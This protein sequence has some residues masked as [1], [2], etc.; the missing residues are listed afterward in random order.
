MPVDTS[1]NSQNAPR[2]ISRKVANE[3]ETELKRAR[4]EISC[5]ECRRLKLKCDKKVPCGSCVRRGCPTICPNGS[6][7]T[8]QG[9]RFVL[10][11]TEHLHRKIVEMGQRIRQLEDALSIFQGGVSDEVHPLLAEDLL[12]IKFGP[13]APKSSNDATNESSNVPINSFGTL[14]INDGGESNYFGLSAG[15]EAGAELD[16]TSSSQPDEVPSMSADVSRLESSLPFSLTGIPDYDQCQSI[17]GSLLSLLPSYPRASALC[18]TYMEHAAWIF[19]PIRRE[20]LIDDILSPVYAFAQKI[21]SNTSESKVECP[22]H[23]IAVL[24]MVFAQGALMDLTL[25]S[26]NQEAEDYFHLGRVALSLRSVFESPTIHT[27]QAL[28]VMGYCYSN[29]SKQYAVNSACKL[30]QSVYRDPSR[31]NMSPKVVQRRRALFWEIFS[32]DLF[33]SLALGHCEFP[34]DETTTMND[35]GE[36]EIGFWRWKHTFTR[37][38]FS[39]VTELTLSAELPSYD[40]ILELDRKVREQVLPPPLNLYR[41]SVQEDYTTPSAYIRGRILFQ[42]RTT[43]MLFIHRSFFAQ[44]LLDFPTNPLRSPYA[45][46]FLAAYRCASATIKTTVLN[47]QVFPDLFMR[48]WP[49]WSHLLSAAVIVGSIVTRAPSTTMAP[50]AWQELNLAV[51]MFSRGSETSSRARHGLA[52]LDKLKVKAYQALEKYRSG[53]TS[54][55]QGSLP[56]LLPEVGGDDELAMFGGQ[57]RVLVTKI[58]SQQN[59]KKVRSSVSLSAA[60]PSQSTTSTPAASDDG[61]SPSDSIPD[62]HPTLVEFL[63]MLPP[64]S[65]PHPTTGTGDAS[66][67]S[68]NQWDAFCLPPQLEFMTPSPAP[69]IYPSPIPQASNSVPDSSFQNSLPQSNLFDPMS[70]TVDDDLADLYLSGVSGIDERWKSFMRD[71]GIWDGSQ[72]YI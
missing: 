1:K 45:P 44:A 40:T 63:K 50:A 38:V 39:Q 58:L 7:S 52:I 46:S 41:S 23:T 42:F 24:Y 57:T 11:D 33:H 37:D 6:L 70:I 31:F 13:E 17:L 8:G 22:E 5:A 29:R 55:I 32:A 12:S 54:N 62:V 60:D 34:E 43:T 64:S 51:E 14:T 61:N 66:T 72:S 27:I 26:C 4:G 15:S 53:A 68:Q 47:F 25:P 9:T 49:I 20:E 19:R 69:V 2:R 48:W 3:E 71:S 59:R 36:V 30:A 67:T 10:A 28:A 18:E 21:Q 56:S 16:G 35:Q 65:M